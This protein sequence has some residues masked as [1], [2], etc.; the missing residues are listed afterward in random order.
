MTEPYLFERGIG[1]QMGDLCRLAV[2]DAKVTQTGEIVTL[3]DMLGRGAFGVSVEVPYA[4]GGVS[5][6][7]VTRCGKNLLNI[8]DRVNGTYE[9]SAG[10]TLSETP[11][12]NASLSLIEGGVE[13]SAAKWRGY[14]MRT[15]F[16]PKGSYRV[17][18]YGENS[19]SKKIRGSI[20]ITDADNVTQQGG[21]RLSDYDSTTFAVNTEKTISAQKQRIW[22]SLTSNNGDTFNLSDLEVVIDGV[23]PTFEPYNGD[24]YTITL[25]ADFYG[26]S[27]SLA[28]GTV[29]SRYAADGTELAEPVVTEIDPISIP[30]LAGINNVWADVG[31]VTVSYYAADAEAF[32]PALWYPTIYRGLTSARYLIKRASGAI[33]NFDDAIAAPLVGLRV[34]LPYDAEGY[35]SVSVTRCGKNL[36]D[37]AKINTYAY[38]NSTPSEIYGK[39]SETGLVS[40][41]GLYASGVYWKGYSI[42]KNPSTRVSVSSDVT[43]RETAGLTNHSICLGF[44]HGNKITTVA[45]DTLTHIV[46]ENLSPTAENLNKLQ[47]QVVGNAGAYLNLNCTFTN[48]QI[49]LG[50]TATAYEPYNGDTYTIALP[51]TIYGG[52]LDVVTGQLVATHDEN[53]NL[54]TNQKLYFLPPT[55]I[56]ALAGVN[57]VW[58]DAGD[59]AVSYRIDNG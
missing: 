22:I 17:R 13:I 30:I 15:A 24:T 57:N 34:A 45:F 48:I 40:K 23:D 16:L 37:F 52:Y 42:K 31:T 49:E 56:S 53:G 43:L 29:T 20:N 58:S 39:K 36:L 38:S 7:D 27:I 32:R 41:Y 19:P 47:M 35:Q 21:V 12:G 5:A 50:S 1:Q 14:G 55:N 9:P 10:Q 25:P 11:V 28:A 51:A 18:I 54:L 44:W 59:V 46:A 33:A 4:S 8:F 2:G 3:E 26:G 6:L